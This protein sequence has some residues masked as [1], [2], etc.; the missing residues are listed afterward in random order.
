MSETYKNVNDLLAGD[1]RAKE[2]YLCMGE[3]AMGSIMMH[4]DSI[5]S[6]DDLKKFGYAGLRTA[7]EE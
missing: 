3:G 2:Y 5:R 7:K 4:Y 6:Y 1:W